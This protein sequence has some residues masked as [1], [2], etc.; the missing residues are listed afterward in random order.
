MN[1]IELSD[2][3]KSTLQSYL[4]TVFN[5][6]RDG[7]QPDL[8]AKINESFEIDGAL[9]MGPYLEITSP[10]KTGQS[11]Q[12]LVDD[13]ILSPQLR[14]LPENNLPLS[15]DVPLYRHQVDAIRK[16]LDVDQKR[17]IVVS[18]GTGSGKT[19]CF[20]IPILNDLLI[21]PTPGVR[22]LLVYPLNALVN[23]QLERL[24]K[25]LTGTPITFG[26]YTSELE[27]T[28]KK[29]RAKNPESPPNEIISREE[30]QGQ[31]QDRIPQILITN[32]AMLEYLLLRPEDSPLFES[33]S[34]RY[35]VL[36]EA[37]TYS[38]AQ[39]IEVSML[40]R[41][42]KHRLEKRRGDV[43]CIAT[44]AT[45]TEDNASAAAAFASD[46]FDETFDESD[47][48]FGQPDLEHA[49]P[50]EPYE[51]DANVYLDSRFEALIL[52]TRLEHSVSTAEVAEHMAV[53]GLIPPSA[54]LQ[55]NVAR[56]A[57]NPRGF[58]YETMRNNDDLIKLREQLR[59]ETPRTLTDIADDFFISRLPDKV[60]RR[61][62]LY[63]LVELCA[64]AR[65][66]EDKASL[67][68]AR[69]HMFMRSPQGIS[70]CLNPNC[71]GRQ[72]PSGAHWSKVFSVRRE[73][74]DSCG[75]RVFPIS[76]CR[77]CGQVFLKTIYME[78]RYYGDLP[79]KENE[80]IPEHE[81]RYFVWRTFEENR[82]LGIDDE[83]ERDEGLDEPRKAKFDITDV[84]LCVRCGAGVS[85]GQCPCAA[86]AD[87][88]PAHITLRLLRED[89]GKKGK[90][91]FE[92]YTSI[93]ECPRC[94]SQARGDTETA[95]AVT[96][97]GSVP[98]SILTYEL[99]RHAPESPEEEICEKPG[100]GRKVLS[101]TDSRQG[102]ARFAS[103]L[104]ST[105]TLQNYQHI[106]P[107]VVR[108]FSKLR[109]V[110]PS[111]SLLA[112]AVRNRAWQL[113]IFHNDADFTSFWRKYTQRREP[114]EQQQ[115]E[116]DDKAQTQLLA[117]FTTGR[118]SRTSLESLGLVAVRYKGL[119]DI[120]DLAREL[121]LDSATT[122]TLLAHL[123]DRLRRQ[124][125]VS[126]PPGVDPADSS[127]GRLDGHPS[128]IKGGETQGYQQVWI[129]K[130]ARHNRRRYL[131]LVLQNHGLPHSEEAVVEALIH[132]F[133]WLIVPEHRIMTGSP[134]EG[135]RIDYN[136]LVFETT[137]L[138]YR[139]RSCQ[140]LY[141][142]G[143]QLPC[144]HIRCDGRIE[145]VDIEQR[146]RANYFYR[147]YDRE[148]VPLRVEEHTA[149][150]T[151][152][153]GRDYQDKFKDGDINVLSC[154][155]TFE[156]GIDLGDLQAIVM[157]NVPPT[158][159]NYRQRSGRAGRRAGGA[160]FIL[161]WTSDRP[162]DQSYFRNPG[163]MISGR[164][165]IPYVAVDNPHIQRRHINAILLSAFLRRRK[166][167][168]ADA[169]TARQEAGMF[170]DSRNV[171]DP[172]FDHIEDWL[173]VNQ[174]H[175]TKLLSRF[176]DSVQNPDI[177]Q[178][179]NHFRSQIQDTCEKYRQMA[180]Y[181][182]EQF[183]IFHEKSRDNYR[184]YG[185]DAEQYDGLLR[186]LREERLIDY[187][188]SSGVLPSYSFPIYA[189][190][191]HL[192][193]TVPGTGQLRLQRD[194]KL[195]I[196]EYAPGAE[197]VADKRIWRSDGVQF[198]KD[199]VRYKEYRICETC[200]HLQHSEGP[201]MPLPAACPI[202]GAPPSL[203]QRKAPRF[204]IPD[205]FY[206]SRK[207]NGKA[208]G[209]YVQRVA[210][211]MK[212]ALLPSNV[213][214]SYQ[215]TP[216]VSCA[217]DRAGN[218][219]YVNE[220][221]KRSRAPGFYI[222][223][224]GEGRGQLVKT[225]K[226]RKK[227]TP[228]SLGHQQTTDT[229]HLTFEDAPASPERLPFWLSLMY[230]LIHGASHALQ[231]E[232]TD[233]D[234]VLFPRH[235]AGRGGWQQTIVLYDDVPGGAGHVQQIRNEFSAVV[236]E[237]FTIANCVDCAAE[238]SCY[239]CLRD[240]SNQGFHHIL[241]RGEVVDYL[242]QLQADL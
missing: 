6:N 80:L 179:I 150:L 106:V 8:A 195:A 153:K 28:V 79:A 188:C 22:A 223:L 230:A 228:V 135:Y 154:S 104:E 36:D 19:E 185:K 115:I 124:K 129:G 229:L 38:G 238:T 132:I 71:G 52:S 39:G 211:L 29:G 100:N 146:Q 116:L 133:D 117:G 170:F 235:A 208:A 25:L 123:L 201:A 20:L 242:N 227:M 119:E 114:D 142:H 213:T 1:P 220:G 91:K 16:L 66:D 109:G 207:N 56:Y 5:V 74:C 7:A 81:T 46:L 191:L 35:I 62:A 33:G 196:R 212:S 98:L 125:I 118:S 204:I 239:S 166:A 86:D 167:A 2:N 199:I 231:I 222:R 45:L 93:K 50:D 32:Y 58:V 158:V 68:P 200:N 137:D 73:T 34:W 237:T 12:Q 92:P 192:P 11:I 145:P 24:R 27:Y 215:I 206:A 17:N 210:N 4:T 164:V 96:V 47:I 122:K 149:Q 78:G 165:R 141:A 126:F 84:Q 224:E 193:S 42:L 139:C 65:P 41:R 69:Y 14:E 105:V 159:A 63:R 89:K 169:W 51:V 236:R 49:R 174:Q 136:N 144:P 177:A 173:A 43:Q 143:P 130:T 61:N 138:W 53:M 40:L 233:I 148:V 217:Y 13:G 221:D 85:G 194:L 87:S 31:D 189:V 113:G 157:S 197:V 67:L 127:F 76:V 175:I 60:D 77:E 226:E 218:L 209:L 26:R 99:Y 198:H 110:A 75:C 163:K 190:E 240:Y 172:H 44:S 219:F 23:D 184:L 121:Q 241:R 186:R 57:T 187:L 120:G 83:E 182:Y 203:R 140:R 111:F 131:K 234:G 205:G 161:T 9:A 101:F 90:A 178:W 10:Y 82:A 160:A 103:Y 156:M 168:L 94:R 97:G 64:L 202:C 102:A 55:D 183:I 216:K 176:A 147:S 225:Q 70:L 128:L 54:D 15:S 48:I 18:S 108:E 214:E 134:T 30:I 59:E 72:S 180:D 181:Y 95:T 112:K 232:R 152:E 155:T 88:Q 21:D 162:H 171:D 107:H 151:P 3:L 37:H